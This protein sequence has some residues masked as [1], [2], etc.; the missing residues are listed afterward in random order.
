MKSYHLIILGALALLCLA[1]TPAQAQTHSHYAAG[2]TDTNGN[3]RP[4]LGEPLRFVGDSGTSKTYHMLPRPPGQPCAGYYTLDERLRTLF[5]DD[6]FS[7]V[8]LSDGQFDAASPSAAH[9]GSWIWMEIVS[10]S[11]P[12]GATF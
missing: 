6:G 5:P 10:V 9:T 7:F 2:F 3:N 4:D 11:G 8:A 1:A 12:Q